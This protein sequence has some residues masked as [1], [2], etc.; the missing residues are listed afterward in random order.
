MDIL[1]RTMYT[2]VCAKVAEAGGG[3]PINQKESPKKENSSGCVV[4]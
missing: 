4:M 1:I 3:T 2:S